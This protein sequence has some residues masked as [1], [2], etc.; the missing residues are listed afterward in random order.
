MKNTFGEFY[1]VSIPPP[2]WGISY[3]LP[4]VPNKLKRK[5]DFGDIAKSESPKKRSRRPET[6]SPAKLPIGQKRKLKDSPSANQNKRMCLPPFLD[7]PNRKLLK[8]RRRCFQVVVD[9]PVEIEILPEDDTRPERNPF[10]W[11]FYPC[12]CTECL[13]RDVEL[14]VGLMEKMCII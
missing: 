5:Q 1:F 8:V 9:E 13:L 3:Q 11:P 10:E 12:P 2:A 14:L 7:S 6:Q 4:D